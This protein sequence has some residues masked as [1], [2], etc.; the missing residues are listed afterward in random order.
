MNQ[1]YAV[2][3]F[4]VNL[5]TGKTALSSGYCYAANQ[6]E[7]YGQSIRQTYKDYPHDSGW[8]SHMVSVTDVIGMGFGKNE[9]G[10]VDRV[11][12]G[13]DLVWTRG[14]ESG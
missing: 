9:D 1:L 14:G 13:G 7:A 2:A 4:A 11:F 12:V 8:I 5:R 6:D 3:T 10:V